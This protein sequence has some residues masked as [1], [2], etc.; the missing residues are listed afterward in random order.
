M[1][2]QWILLGD[3]SAAVLSCLNAKELARIERSGK[4]IDGDISQAW[5]ALVRSARRDLE[6]RPWLLQNLP[7]NGTTKELLMELVRLRRYLDVV[8]AAWFPQIISVTPASLQLSPL[9]NERSRVEVIRANNAP[10]DDSRTALDLPLVAKIPLALAAKL[11]EKLTVGLHIELDR[12]HSSESV[13]LGLD[14]PGK[15]SESRTN[16][17]ILFAPLSGRCKM[18]FPGEEGDLVACAMA[19]LADGHCASVETYAVVSESGDIEFLRFCRALG[20]LDRSGRI[21]HNM[22]PFWTRK[23]SASINLQ[24]NHV[25]HPTRV[26]TKWS[27]D[28]L[29]REVQNHFEQTQFFEFDAAW[30]CA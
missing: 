4:A 28:G 16:I 29:P 19:A 13:W 1:V 17:S 30:S 8:P 24:M 26:S 20:S 22:L 25:S 5:E 11:G 7:K 12:G 3:A 9:V 18:Q 15:N 10:I 6:W 21:L 27:S 2:L 23:V 14:F